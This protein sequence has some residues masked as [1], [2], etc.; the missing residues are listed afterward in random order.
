MTIAEQIYKNYLEGLKYRGKEQAK[1]FNITYH[2]Y[3]RML[4]KIKAQKRKE[5]LAR[6]MT[7]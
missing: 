3:H 7:A 6:K 4:G 5:M 2:Q 1:Y